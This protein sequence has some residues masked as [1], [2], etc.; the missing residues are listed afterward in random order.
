MSSNEPQKG[1][2]LQFPEPE[3]F[4]L[5]EIVARAQTLQEIESR[6]QHFARHGETTEHMEG[7]DSDARLI[8]ASLVLTREIQSPNE[9]PLARDILI[10][11]IRIKRY[12]E[13]P[14]QP[15]NLRELIEISVMR[16]RAI[17]TVNEDY[18]LAIKLIAVLLNV[19]R[20]TIE[21]PPE[22]DQELEYTIR[23][24]FNIKLNQ[25]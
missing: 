25:P 21:N 6:Y 17:A 11:L 20:N 13:L 14:Y 9:E 1:E 5:A 15:R 10:G 3:Q 4:S 23:N 16:A 22:K 18:E 7:F 19:R 2:L 8:R 12:G 24:L